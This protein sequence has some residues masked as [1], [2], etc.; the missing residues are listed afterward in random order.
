M[1]AARFQTGL[2]FAILDAMKNRSAI[3]AL[4]VLAVFAA[5][6][7]PVYELAA[8]APRHLQLRM[9]FADCV[10]R[11]D[12]AGMEAVCRE[13]VELVADDPLWHFNLA[14]ALAYR[15]DPSE[16]FAELEKSVRL[17]VRDVKMIENDADLK[18]I[19]GDPRFRKAVDLAKELGDSLPPGG[20]PVVPASPA[21]DWT[22]TVAETN[23]VWNFDAN[24]FVAETDAAAVTSAVPRDAAGRYNG[25]AK[26]NIS[27]W[28]REGTAAGNAGDLY[29]NRDGGHSRLAVTNYPGMLAVRMDEKARAL[30]LDRLTPNMCFAHPVIG[31]ASLALTQGFVWRSAGRLHATDQSLAMRMQSFYMNNQFWVFPAVDDFSGVPT[32]RIDRFASAAPWQLV[33]EGRSW[34]DQEFVRA[35]AAA[36]AAMRPDTKRAAL[37]A[38][39]FAPTLQWLFRRS[40]PGVKT[41]ADYL[42]EKAH[43]TAFGK[44]DLDVEAL[45]RRAH[46]LAPEEIPPVAFLAVVNSSRF[47]VKYPQPGAD[48]PDIGP[49][50]VS[51]T[52][53]S[54][55]FVL[56]DALAKRTVLVKAVPFP[57][58]GG[59]A[60]FAWAVVHGDPSAVSIEPPLGES[61]LALRGGLAQITVDRRRIPPG[62]RIDV[63]CFAKRAGTPYGAPAFVSFSAVALEKR[64]WRADGKVASID[65]TNP[66]G[67]YCDPMVALPRRWRDEYG[68]DAAGE[69]TGFV[70][71]S[72]D[73][74][75]LGEF[76]RRG[77]RVVERAA[78][79]SP[80]RTVKVRYITRET[81]VENMPPELTY[82]DED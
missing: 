19:S 8:L 58:E 48:Y 14:C 21:G 61:P 23:L 73:G 15:D 16:A 46:A 76:T 7:T 17:G 45:V 60:E 25:P 70:R 65:Y 13:G 33:T 6:A 29:F 44:K 56:R 69:C 50:V 28:M 75:K 39:L 63:A 30:G 20:T 49:E 4:A 3:F 68:Y 36:S 72:A 32:N 37:R 27:A 64:E 54:V 77:E 22:I 10:R 80:K 38:H 35:A 66:D 41:D 34:S 11:S 9:R 74:T 1:T 82:I 67:L 2:R 55:A 78:D 47:P 5:A 31:N 53:S 59:A 43:P 79:G 18:R 52:A 62:G 57:L 81:G 40:R 51:A 24:C 42:T 12:A 26:K 71:I